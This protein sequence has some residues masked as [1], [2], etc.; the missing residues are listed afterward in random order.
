M[1]CSQPL[2]RHARVV[3]N[4][5]RARVHVHVRGDELGHG[6]HAVKVPTTMLARG[7]QRPGSPV[8]WELCMCLCVRGG[9]P[10]KPC[11]PQACIISLS[12]SC[13]FTLGHVLFKLLFSQDDIRKKNL[14]LC[15][16]TLATALAHTTGLP[17]M[18]CLHSPLPALQWVSWVW[19][20]GRSRLPLKV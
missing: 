16:Q 19:A 4:M 13:S 8:H 11:L 20:G 5:L 2:R 18:D 12:C 14:W 15:Q 1:L 10:S 17:Q 9:G 6:T 7:T 3:F